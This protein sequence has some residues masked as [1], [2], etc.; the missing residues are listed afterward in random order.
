VAGKV[1]IV[2]DNAIERLMLSKMI[3]SIGYE[4]I[5]AADIA[6]A[7]PLLTSHQFTAALLDIEL[8]EQDGFALLKYLVELSAANPYPILMMT[9][10][11]HRI[12]H[13]WQSI[14]L[15]AH[16]F[17][18]KPLQA[19]TIQNKIQSSIQKIQQSLF[20]NLNEFSVYTFNKDGV[21]IHG[22][23]PLALHSE[24]ELQW[25]ILNSF[26]L[27]S[28][29]VKTAN[30]EKISNGYLTQCQFVD[31]TTLQKNSIDS[32]CK[33]TAVNWGPASIANQESIDT[34]EKSKI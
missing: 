23:T 34:A 15:G 11:K 24:F 1:L 21:M 19:L 2:D 33:A 8:P 7:I 3:E 30:C 14:E 5:A 27:K 13:V 31:L 26:G 16:D 32:F 25:P 12:Q 28:V 29:R 9:A 17:M 22:K 4:P 20:E 10:S 6:T 18:V